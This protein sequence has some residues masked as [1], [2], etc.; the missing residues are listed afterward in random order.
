MED[1]TNREIMYEINDIQKKVEDINT[2]SLPE[3]KGMVKY[4]NGSVAE[5]IKWKER[6][7]GG[8]YV[9]LIVVVPIMSWALYKL[10]NLD[11]T[12]DDSIKKTLQANVAT[13]NY[14]K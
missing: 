10:A 3:I 13:I 2:K 1:P 11:H 9:V 12:I 4:T 8:A 14:V 7:T 6:M 5:V